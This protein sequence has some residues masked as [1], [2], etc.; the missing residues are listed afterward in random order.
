MRG[1]VGPPEALAGLRQLGDCS[2]GETDRYTM[3]RELG[4]RVYLVGYGGRRKGEKRGKREGKRREEK[5][6]RCLSRRR[7]D[8]E[9]ATAQAGE[10]AEDHL[11]QWKGRGRL[12]VGRACLLQ[13]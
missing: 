1:S 8:R 4:Y 13:G 11:P 7:A 6:I 5:G 12:E 10:E 2:G 9:K 3:Q